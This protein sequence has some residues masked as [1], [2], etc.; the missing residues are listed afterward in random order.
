[1]SKLTTVPVGLIT[2]PSG[3]DGA[4]LQVKNKAIVPVTTQDQNVTPIT[5][6][7]FDASVGVLT[8]VFLNNSSMPV[9]GFPT[10]SDIPQGQQGPEGE[11]GIDGRDGRDGRDGKDGEIGCVGPV[12]ETGDQGEDGRD[13]LEGP[14]G[15]IGIQGPQGKRGERGKKGEQ[16]DQGPPGK[17]GLPGIEGPRG[18]IGKQGPPGRIN[19][20]V[21][22][23]DPG[24][25]LGI[26]GIWVNPLIGQVA[27]DT[28]QF[29]S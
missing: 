9:S 4:K 26:G 13:G 18:K 12:G 6:M 8:I 1:M 23:T 25:S 16:G 15:P 21:S 17:Q 22:E 20:L 5:K 29:F 3:Q 14:I 28:A 19:I 7:E 27:D 11:P 24:P 2:A 10:L